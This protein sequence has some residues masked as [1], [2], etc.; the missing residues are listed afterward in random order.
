MLALGLAVVV[1]SVLSGCAAP[2]TVNVTACSDG[3]S[4]LSTM[5]KNIGSAGEDTSL[6]TELDGEMQVLVQEISAL[7]A[8][9]SPLQIA[10]DTSA[11]NMLLLFTLRKDANPPYSTSSLGDSSD[12]M[13]TS[14]GL[15]TPYM[16]AVVRACTTAIVDDS[17]SDG[18]L[19]GRS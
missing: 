16:E 17:E 1:A 4:L 11:E 13:M 9:S 10:M 3:T 18:G 5:A 19:L 14:L 7:N 12:D 8:E 15:L 6:Y 2:K